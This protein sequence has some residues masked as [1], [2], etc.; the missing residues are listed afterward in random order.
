MD[1]W[2]RTFAFENRQFCGHPAIAREAVYPVAGIR[3]LWDAYFVNEP[4]TICSA[5]TVCQPDYQQIPNVIT[6]HLVLVDLTTFKVIMVQC[7]Q[8]KC[9]CYTL[10]TW[11]K[12]IVEHGVKY[13]TTKRRFPVITTIISV[14]SRTFKAMQIL[15]WIKLDLL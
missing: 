3:S 5:A 6:L 12:D 10:T 7:L 14:S 15:I 2:F 9:F 4:I 13:L 1:R 8:F 11:K